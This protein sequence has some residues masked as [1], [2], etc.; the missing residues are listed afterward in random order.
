MNVIIIGYGRVGKSL[1]DLM[2]KSENNVTV[3]DK[4][5]D[6]IANVSSD[7]PGRVVLGLGY[8]EDVLIEAGIETCDALAA[9]TS[10]DNVNLMAS[11][12]A[13]Q[14]Y[15]VERVIARVVNLNRLGVY[16]QLG[17]D[18]VCDTEIVA[19]N[20]FA[21]I[22]SRKSHHLDT[23]GSYEVTE[24]AVNVGSQE[25]E[26]KD[27]ENVGDVRVVLLEHADETIR[28]ERNTF[29]QDGDTVLVVAHVDD[30]PRLEQYMKG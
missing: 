4:D 28:P 13:R 7:F 11:E 19:E 1:A 12:V 6:V 30:I 2:S 29:V 17:L 20:I 21:K 14:L 15:Q 18:F 9:V 5:P 16:R 23:V 3:I 25:L 27:I 8:D 22:R 10:S 26:V 24:F